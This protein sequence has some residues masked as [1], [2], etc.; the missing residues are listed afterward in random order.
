MTQPRKKL[1]IF[2]LKVKLLESLKCVNTKPQSSQWM[3]SKC[4]PLN[5]MTV[6]LE[7]EL[8]IWKEKHE[9]PLLP[10]FG[11]KSSWLPIMHST[12]CGGNQDQQLM[13]EGWSPGQLAVFELTLVHPSMSENSSSSAQT[14]SQQSWAQRTSTAEPL[15]PM[16][17]PSRPGDTNETRAEASES[18]VTHDCGSYSHTVQ[19]IHRV[20]VSVCTGFAWG[21]CK[22]HVRFLMQL[23][24]FTTASE[25]HWT[26]PA[27]LPGIMFVCYCTD[28]LV[29][30]LIRAKLSW[31]KT[32][33]TEKEMGQCRKQKDI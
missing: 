5:I 29:K 6:Q 10:S 32:L 9:K 17:M 23:L 25:K 20:F 33:H 12:S 27:E 28:E 4:S 2:K 1:Q 19:C 3:S 16:K 21:L 7:K 18:S 31:N 13:V 26:V 24:L 30:L 15:K 14:G 22:A 11:P 8:L